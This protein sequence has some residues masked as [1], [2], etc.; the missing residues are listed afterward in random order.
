[1]SRIEKIG[2]VHKGRLIYR[3]GGHSSTHNLWRQAVRI[4]S[5]R[6]KLSETISKWPFSRLK[7]SQNDPYLS[8]KWSLFIRDSL[9]T[10]LGA[11]INLNKKKEKLQ[12]YVHSFLASCSLSGLKK[13]FFKHTNI[14]RD[15]T[16]FLMWKTFWSVVSIILSAT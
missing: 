14:I 9:L 12:L 15:K 7:F 5:E 6:S 13:I 2:H 16:Y 10:D 11:T 1:M 4:A 3:S 8:I